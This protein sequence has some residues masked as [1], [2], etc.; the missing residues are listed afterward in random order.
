MTW[1]LPAEIAHVTISLL[2]AVM[3]LYMYFNDR[4][5]FLLLWFFSWSCL[6]V[7]F[8]ME[9]LLF[10]GYQH[11]AIIAIGQISALIA[12][13][14]LT[15]GT[16]LFLE[17]TLPRYWAPLTSLLIV[18]II[19][20]NILRQPEMAVLLPVLVFSLIIFVYTG[21]CC[22][23]K[24]KEQPDRL[25][26]NIIGY[27]F[28]LCGLHLLDYPW[29]RPIEWFA[30]W[31]YFIAALLGLLIGC[32]LVLA[33][34][35]KIKLSLDASE[36]LYFSIFESS[37]TPLL[38]LDK[39]FRLVDANAACE[40]LFKTE[41]QDMK[42]H[43]W[44]DYVRRDDLGKV[45]NLFPRQLKTSHMKSFECRGIDKLGGE[46]EVMI[47]LSPIPATGQY[48]ASLV[49][50]TERKRAEE[51][52]RHLAMHDPLTDLP[53][54]KFLMETLPRQMLNARYQKTKLGVFFLDLDNFKD[55]NDRYGHEAG[56]K[57]LC[58]AASVI[59]QA[60]PDSDMVA[61]VGGDEFVI[62]LNGIASQ[63]ELASFAEKIL[64]AFSEAL[65][66]V[67]HTHR[68]GLSIG[69]SCYPDDD[70]RPEGL[71]RK[72]DQAMYVAKS[73]GGNGYA[74]FADPDSTYK[75]NKMSSDLY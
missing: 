42:G 67:D 69:I 68:L 44:S 57:S 66:Q 10:Q 71:L 55:I 65:S 64:S 41:R 62:L 52:V 3:Y 37:G 60:A 34:Y 70:D 36:S 51:A 30:P 43:R 26:Y 27:S 15:G 73:Q 29:L 35:Q 72:A 7:K 11:I 21:W 6:V 54:R 59:R 23:V 14:T 24:S 58:L 2:L 8:V 38:I 9:L 74:V 40:K 50:V 31:G 75:P 1:Y 46:R 53:N 20:A 61:R 39:E 12:F 45:L 4:R 63:Q 47:T 5:A 28:I 33:Y 17:R 18:W 16:L 32:G 22:L 49:D 25:I 56:D 13:V 48:V 19:G